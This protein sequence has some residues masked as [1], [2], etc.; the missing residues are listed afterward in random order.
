MHTIEKPRGNPDA[1]GRPT[2]RPRSSAPP[3]G[4]RHP[5]GHAAK[6][7]NHAPHRFTST[8]SARVPIVPACH[9]R[10]S[11]VSI[12]FSRRKFLV[13][14][15]AVPLSA[16]CSPPAAA[17]APRAAAG[18]V[19]QSRHRQGDGHRDRADVLDLGARHREPGQALHGE[20]PEDQGQRGQ[21]RPGRPA[22]P[23]A[24]HGDP[25]RQGAPDVAQMEFQYIPSFTLA[26]QPARPAPY[27]AAALKDNYADW[28]WGQVNAQ[29]RALG[30]P[31][32]HRPDGPALPRG[33]ASP[34]ASRR[35][36]P[37]T[38]SPPPR[39]SYTTPNPK[40]Y[41][42]NVAP[43]QPGRVHRPTCGRPARAVRFD[44]QRRSPS[45]SPTTRP[46][47][48]SKFWATWSPGRR[49]RQRPDFNDSWYQGLASGKY[50]TCRSPPGA[51]CSCRAAPRPPRASGGPRLCRSGRPASVSSNWGGSTDAVLKATQEPDRRL[52]A[53]AVHQH[54]PGDRR[55]CSPPSSSCSRR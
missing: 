51:R 48:S 22:L 27:G 21:R 39:A 37:G 42:V 38:S 24:A 28:I 50:A 16:W 18:P 3:P 26:E 10:S 15:G 34:P 46:R 47:R 44:G 43:N 14:A 2:G 49:R 12:S 53:G 8:R 17:T 32:G 52:P 23:E 31:A 33:P 1:D 36:R 7:R 40:S 20:V 29:R 30:H 25:V 11:D 55:C 5:R 19:S 13:A 4:P 54:R 6:Q 41:L 35:R 9:P 45:T